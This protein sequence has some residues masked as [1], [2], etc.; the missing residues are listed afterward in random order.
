MS[1]NIEK[2]NM[3]RASRNWDKKG[4]YAKEFGRNTH[5]HKLKCGTKS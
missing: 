2:K 1:N 5:K 3:H 4:E